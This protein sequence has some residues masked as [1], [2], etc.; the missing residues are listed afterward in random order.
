MK[1]YLDGQPVSDLPAG[2]SSANL[3]DIER[4]SHT[5]QVQVSDARGT[6]LIS[7]DSVTFFYQQTS[8]NRRPVLR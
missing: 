5:L 7:S 6:K 8:V 3:T 4:G 1:L 2:S